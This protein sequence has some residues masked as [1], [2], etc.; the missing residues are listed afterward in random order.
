MLH[1]LQWPY[2]Y[3][4]SVC[5]KCFIGFQTYV[6]ANVICCKCSMRMRMKW[7]QAEQVVPIGAVAPHACIVAGGAMSVGAAALVRG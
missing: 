2:T 3:V 1:M 6:A 4:V 7:G 5:S